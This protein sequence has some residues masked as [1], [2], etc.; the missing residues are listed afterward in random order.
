M[1]KIDQSTDLKIKEAAKRVFLEKGFGG[2][3]TRDIAENAETNIALVNY[4]FRSKEKLFQEIFLESFM[5]TFSPITRILNDDLPIEVKIYKLVENMTDLLRRDPLLPMFVLS[6][7]RS[8]NSK[9]C[10]LVC[11]LHQQE[12]NAFI[13]QLEAEAAK[14]NIRKIDFDHI[15][16]DIMSMIIFPFVSMNLIKLKKDL[17][18][19]AFYK[20]MDDRKKHIPEMILSYLRHPV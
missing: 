19:E 10:D 18:T 4:Y 9:M 2:A 3:T 8:E 16:L 14:G 7:L 15:E 1:S 11:E 5:E 20:M 13:Q 6:E 17:T 12:G